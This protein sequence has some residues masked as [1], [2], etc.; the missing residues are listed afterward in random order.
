MD[1]SSDQSETLAPCPSPKR[2]AD[3]LDG[4]VEL[5]TAEKQHVG[6]CVACQAWLERHTAAPDLRALSTSSL[7]RRELAT[8]VGGGMAFA[9]EPE[10]QALKQRISFSQSLRRESDSSST[11]VDPAAVHSA[12]VD[13]SITRR[14][15]EKTLPSRYVVDR[16]LASG[17]IAVVYLAFDS[18]LSRD[19]AIKVLAR[20]SV[21][22]QQRFMREA[23]VLAELQHANIVRVFDV[24]ILRSNRAPEAADAESQGSGTPYIVMEYV[25]GGTVASLYSRS[26]DRDFRR[27]AKLIQQAAEGLSVAHAAGLIHRDVKPR[28]LL[29]DDSKEVCKVADFGLARFVDAESTQITLTDEIV[30]TP[31]FMSPEQVGHPNDSGEAVALTIA[32]DIYSLGATLYQLTTGQ[33]PFQGSTA[34]ILR[35]ITESEPVPPRAINPDIPPVLELI[36]AKAMEKAPAARYTTMQALADDLGRYLSG[37]PTLARPIT[38]FEQLWRWTKRNRSLAVALMA[39]I[40]LLTALGL[41][42]TIAAG[43]LWSQKR[44]ILSQQQQS[45][46]ELCKQ[47]A[48]ADPE[49]LPLV[50]SQLKDY[51][52]SVVPELDRLWREES[53]ERKRLNVACALNLLAEDR[54]QYIISHVGDC[55]TTPAQC[56]AIC[57]ALS[58]DR[59]RSLELLAAEYGGSLDSMRMKLA[60]VALQ[61]GNTHYADSLVEMH[62]NLRTAFIHTLPNWHGDMSS[63][64]QTLATHTNDRTSMALALAMG[65]IERSEFSAEQES[66]LSQAIVS[67][68]ERTQDTGVLSSLV[69]LE[70]KMD[71]LAREAAVDELV[72]ASSESSLAS[73]YRGFRMLPVKSGSFVMGAEAELIGF[74]NRPPHPVTLSRDFLL[75]DR[76]VS[77][78]LFRTFLASREKSEDGQS[79]KKWTCDEA[80]SATGSQ[81]AQRVTWLEAVEFCNWLSELHGFEPFY[82]ATE[83]PYHFVAKRAGQSSRSG[84]RL[85]TEAEFEYACRAGTQTL[86]SF[87]DSMEYFPFYVA[88][89]NNTRIA[90]AECGSLLPNPWGFFEM[91]GN[92]W[93]W[94]QD[95]HQEFKRD[96]LRVD[97]ECTVPSESGRVFR[98]GG[99]ATYTGYPESSAR[100]SAAADVRFLNLGFRVA[101]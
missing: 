90:S 37:Q 17:G 64:I 45:L 70:R 35:R 4:R 67:V 98:G 49:S 13:G 44:Q 31:A 99:V 79:S 78:A 91:H 86:Y 36:C 71:T 51:R 83:A 96:V 16:L 11:H 5:G 56:R 1:E 15:L 69:W 32:T 84:Y 30:G 40:C 39:I 95:W 25:A 26:E 87:G 14:W 23:R 88:W 46:R 2:L 10:F 68:R 33:S 48:V 59:D 101:R 20:E 22:E 63:L 12:R 75:A 29:L 28:N 43:T 92:V 38:Q 3:W 58:H 85:P 54:S 60:V 50:F 74:D 65:L 52:M 47:V 61:L 80:I 97:P 100:G 42:S 53:L 76:E 24:G 66:Q 21:R 34:S 94:T 82:V 62:P 41:G 9:Q 7:G 72:D 19:V 77:V 57:L 55:Q 81:P 6:A 93:E 89:S 73:D 18:H 8:S 27:I